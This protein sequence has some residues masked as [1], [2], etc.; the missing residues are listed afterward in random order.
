MWGLK[1]L[2]ISVFP[3]RAHS[4]ASCPTAGG[5]EPKYTTDGRDVLP[6]AVGDHLG[7]AVAVAISHG[8]VGRSQ[9][10]ADEVGHQDERST[11]SRLDKCPHPGGELVEIDI[12]VAAFLAICETIELVDWNIRK[13]RAPVAGVI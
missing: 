11:L 8:R 3:S 4:F 12:L 9:V 7:P 13:N 6:F 1:K 5:F 2:A 10:D